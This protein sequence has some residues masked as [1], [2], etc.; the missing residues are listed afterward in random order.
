MNRKNH[1]D[2][3]LLNDNFSDDANF[4]YHMGYNSDL[5]N[6]V[7]TNH[8]YTDDEANRILQGF[9]DC[10]VA[11]KMNLPEI[12]GKSEKQINYADDVR[13]AALYKQIE[14]AIKMVK[15]TA[16]V[17]PCE[18]SKPYLAAE[19]VKAA[20]KDLGDNINTYTDAVLFELAD[21]EYMPSVWNKLIKMT[22]AR[23][24]LDNYI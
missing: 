2:F 3:E 13:S 8:V 12:E 17:E 16:G 7:E 19:K 15:D 22:S 1:N 23:E 4:C 11:I 9:N 20:Y 24:I 14:M 21:E 6:F 5:L 10:C 18:N